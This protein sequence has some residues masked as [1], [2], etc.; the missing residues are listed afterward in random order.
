MFSLLCSLPPCLILRGRCSLEFI[1]LHSRIHFR[2]DLRGTGS[3][4][5][6]IVS[7]GRRTTFDTSDYEQRILIIFFRWFR[8]A[9]RSNYLN[10]S[11]LRKW[12]FIE[13]LFSQILGAPIIMTVSFC[14][15]IKLDA[16]NANVPFVDSVWTTVKGERHA[17]RARIVCLILYFFPTRREAVWCAL[18]PLAWSELRKNPAGSL[19]KFSNI[20]IPPF[21]LHFHSD[22]TVWSLPPSP[23]RSVTSTTSVSAAWVAFCRLRRQAYLTGV[24]W[25]GWSIVILWVDKSL[26]CTVLSSEYLLLPSKQASRIGGKR[27]HTQLCSTLTSSQRRRFGT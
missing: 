14:T 22:S 13:H 24:I 9:S 8:S 10:S 1:R 19:Q 16:R 18:A 7:S 27:C 20:L 11:I 15:R 17:E 2:V 3:V 4:E 6:A 12:Y 26:Y 25:L 21:Q 5:S 23:V